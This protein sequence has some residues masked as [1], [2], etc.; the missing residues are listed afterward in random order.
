MNGV[1]AMTFT[2]G[3]VLYYCAAL[4]PR[5]E[6]WGEP[7]VIDDSTD[8]AFLTCTETIAGHPAVAYV[9]SP[10]ADYELRY[11]RALDPQGT[12]WGPIEYL[13]V[14]ANLDRVSLA[15]VHGHPAIAYGTDGGGHA[16]PRYV[17]ALDPQGTEWG[18][19]VNC[20]GGASDSLEVFS[21]FSF[22]M[23]NL[24]VYRDRPGCI[25]RAGSFGEP[26]LYY[27]CYSD[28]ALGLV[29]PEAKLILET[30]DSGG[31]SAMQPLVLNR[32]FGPEL[33]AFGMV[34]GELRLYRRSNQPG[35]NWNLDG[36]LHSMPDGYGTQTVTVSIV[37]GNPA[38]LIQESAAG[39]SQLV[40]YR[41]IDED[42]QS[43][44]STPDTLNFLGEDDGANSW[45]ALGELDGLPAIF[46]TRSDGIL[47]RFLKY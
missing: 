29:W 44:P 3:Q 38:V 36:T 26:E 2:E 23:S 1:P 18:E 14:G 43:W 28:D 47:T 10:G 11:R 19:P 15:I 17:R 6:D 33:A 7:T 24:V 21:E 40:Y 16:D 32:S 8:A 25:F 45:P 39:E 20:D 27:F 34:D 35:N 41:A 46:T 31:N 42:G 30:N 13:E 12:S 4:D 37:Q 22:R 9:A 5:G